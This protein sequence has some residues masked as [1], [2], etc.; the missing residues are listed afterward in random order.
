M[1]AA[2]GFRRKVRS[3]AAAT[4]PY[5]AAVTGNCRR[6]GTSPHPPPKHPPFWKTAGTSKKFDPFRRHFFGRVSRERLRT[7]YTGIFATQGG[8]SA[9]QRSKQPGLLH[10][11]FYSVL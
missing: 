7:H 5:S 2:Q 3:F 1:A 6:F 8:K 11:I 9:F 4:H 10:F